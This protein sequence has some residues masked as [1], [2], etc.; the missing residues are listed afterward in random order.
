M[1]AIKYT[2]ALRLGI[3]RR[4]KLVISRLPIYYVVNDFGYRYLCKRLR[5]AL[6]K[7]FGTKT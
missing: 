6:L 2:A 7:A 4:V 5:R 1:A 3:Q